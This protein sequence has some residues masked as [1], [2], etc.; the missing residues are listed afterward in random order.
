MAPDLCIQTYW[1]T[2]NFV[3]MMKSAGKWWYFP[4]SSHLFTY[5]TTIWG[6]VACCSSAHSVV[7]AN[8]R[9]EFWSLRNPVF[10]NF[11]LSCPRNGKVEHIEPKQFPFVNIHQS[12]SNRPQ[13]P[14]LDKRKSG[15]FS[16]EKLFFG[17]YRLW[18]T[19]DENTPLHMR[20]PYCPID[21]PRK[22][23]S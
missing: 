3:P 15:L 6:P 22:D 16:H 9:A 13:I 14:R 8:F 12:E 17:N 11:S 23:G 18:L 20:G 21:C 2:V 10:C 5:L 4:N 7:R 1:C 19:S